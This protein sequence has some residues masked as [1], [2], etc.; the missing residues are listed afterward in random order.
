LHVMVKKF[1][2]RHGCVVKFFV[3]LWL[4][5]CLSSPQTPP[6][7][8]EGLSSEELLLTLENNSLTYFHGDFKVQL[9]R[10]A[11]SNAFFCVNTNGW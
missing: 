6:D 4:T 11:F 10:N 2:R 3:N 9:I 7:K 1:R 5:S 8:A